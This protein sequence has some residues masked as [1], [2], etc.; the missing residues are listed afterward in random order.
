MMYHREHAVTLV[1]LRVIDDAWMA[2]AFASSENTS[3][4]WCFTISRVR[5]CGVPVA[6]PASSLQ[7]WRRPVR[8][9]IVIRL[10]VRTRLF[11]R[12]DDRGK[13][14][15]HPS[16]PA[17]ILCAGQISIRPRWDAESHI[18]AKGN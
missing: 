13:D 18:G 7:Q 14:I 8:D 12:L 17:D 10:D 2:R 4:M 5:R 11:F 15:Q 6:V 16:M 1:D 9:G 3:F